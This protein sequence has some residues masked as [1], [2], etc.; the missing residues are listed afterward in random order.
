MG[1]K[2]CKN[3]FFH[4]RLF[5]T[6]S[7]SDSHSHYSANWNDQRYRLWICAK[8][9]C[10]PP[11]CSTVLHGLLDLYDLFSVYEDVAL[12]GETCLVE[13]CES[14]HLSKREMKHFFTEVWKP[15]VN[16]RILKSWD[17]R[18]YVVDQ[19]GQRKNQHI[20]FLQ[21]QIVNWNH[22]VN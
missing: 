11:T 18:R 7:D 10:R 15:L 6:P 19:N 8:T 13:N 2:T 17:W 9:T 12:M 3:S 20:V 21:G 22:T 1:N 5:H 16:L 4:L 14:P